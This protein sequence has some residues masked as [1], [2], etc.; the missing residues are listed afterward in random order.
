MVN[1]ITESMYDEC[2]NNRNEYLIMVSIVN[3]QKNNKA[4]KIDNHK[5]VHRYRN[6]MW[7]STVASQICVQWRDGSAL[8][9]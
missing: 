5:L 2:D 8:L 4:V 7:R 3:Y 6:S 9:Y 1:V